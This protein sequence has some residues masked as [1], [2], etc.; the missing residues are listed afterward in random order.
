CPPNR[1]MIPQPAPRV[2]DQNYLEA[3]G[4]LLDL[5]GILDRIDRGGPEMEN[6]PRLARLREGLMALLG[7]APRAETIQTI[8]SLDY[9]P[10]WPRP[11]PR[12]L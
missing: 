1:I 3:R 7:S 12:D 9:D 5:A 6:D 10:N 4:R 11:L 8:F 2:L